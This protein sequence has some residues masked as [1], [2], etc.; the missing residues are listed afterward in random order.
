MKMILAVLLNNLSDL[1]SSNLLTKG[2]RVTKF[3]STAGLL[4]GGTTTLM[5]VINDESLDDCLTIIRQMISDNGP[6]DSEHPRATL[7][8]LKVK[9]YDQVTY[10]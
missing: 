7:Y 8:V 4:S 5:I 1:V 10:E 2:F 9:D 3:A 6:S